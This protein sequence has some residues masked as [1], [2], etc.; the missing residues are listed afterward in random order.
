MLKKLPAILVAGTHSGCGKT[1]LAL[2][3]M[4]ALKNRG[5]TIAPF[6]SGPDFIDPGFHNLVCQRASHNL[7]TWML[8][9]EALSRI[10]WTNVEGCDCAIIEGA[11]GLFDGSS[12]KS[13][14]GSAAHLSKVLG[15][16]VLLVVDARGMGRSVAALVKGYMEYDK[17]LKVVGVIVNRAG[18]SKHRKILEGA[19]EELGLPFVGTVGRYAEISLPS[20]HLGLV[21][22]GEYQS[23]SSVFDRLAEVIENDIPIDKLLKVMAACG[24]E[25]KRPESFKAYHEYKEIHPSNH[26]PVRL[27]VARDK[28]FCFYYQRN[29]DILRELGAE[30]IFFSPLEGQFIPGPV[31]G[32][33]LGGGYPELYCEELTQN[34]SVIKS[35]RELAQKGLPIYAECGGFMYLGQGL[36]H[37]G[38]FFS[39]CSVHPARFVM[40]K[41]FQALGYRQVVLNDNCLLGTPGTRFKGHEFRYSR[42]AD[43]TDAGTSAI[44]VLDANGNPVK[45]PGFVKGNIFAGYVHAHFDSNPYIAA[46]FIDRCRE[47]RDSVG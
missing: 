20:R 5:L 33:Y 38:H 40:E 47:Y 2:G 12:P 25:I 43:A 45:V 3:L 10:F 28:A 6:K 34:T 42:P 29:L 30:L 36:E 4:A 39:W 18:S 32:L 46:R 44:E 22:A 1:T 17:G 15:V 13:E 9:Q 26:A 41:R 7:D 35:I 19:L 14:T 21:T 31:H 23:G 24:P 16:P 8:S 27:A 37:H 11:M